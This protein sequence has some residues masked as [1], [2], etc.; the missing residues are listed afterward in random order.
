MG[1]IAIATLVSGSAC[2]HHDFA[3]AL[4]VERR[5]N[6]L[7]RLARKQR[8]RFDIRDA[9]SCPGAARAN[10]AHRLR[11]RADYRTRPAVFDMKLYGIRG[12]RYTWPIHVYVSAA[13]WNGAPGG[14]CHHGPCSQSWPWWKLAG[15]LFCRIKLLSGSP[16]SGWRV[17]LYTRHGALYAD[18][19][20]DRRRAVSL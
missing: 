6:A 7:D 17:W 12:T 11:G 19:H 1:H 15:W 4:A 9:F 5:R 14:G 3:R 10:R 2:A 16:S 13:H 18:L 8:A 20:I